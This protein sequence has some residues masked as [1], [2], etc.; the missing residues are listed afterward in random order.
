[1]SP[2]RRRRLSGMDRLSLSLV[3]GDPAEESRLFEQRRRRTGARRDR[4]IGTL[5]STSRRRLSSGR[6][7]HRPSIVGTARLLA[8]TTSRRFH[9]P[10]ATA[11]SLVRQRMLPTLRKWREAL[12]SCRREKVGAVLP[13]DLEPSALPI[14]RVHDVAFVGPQR[15]KPF[16]VLVG[17][18]RAKRPGRSRGCCARHPPNSRIDC[19]GRS[20]DPAANRQVGVATGV[21]DG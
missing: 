2:T 10:S 21:D 3:L 1:M 19:A 12:Y 17:P 6:A 15:C 11:I 18:M 20:C 14:R 5:R 8:S 9:L 16:C 7:L 13:D 4:C